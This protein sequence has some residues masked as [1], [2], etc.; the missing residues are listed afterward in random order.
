[1]RFRECDLE[2]RS[3]GAAFEAKDEKSLEDREDRDVRPVEGLRLLAASL[4]LR[5][6]TPDLP[7]PC[8]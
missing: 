3:I 7:S 6:R 8:E 4:A 1:M 5:I 2:N